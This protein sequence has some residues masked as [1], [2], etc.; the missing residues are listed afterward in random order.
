MDWNTILWYSLCELLLGKLQQK[1]SGFSLLSIVLFRCQF[2]KKEA[3][4]YRDRDLPS[5]G[6][7]DNNIMSNSIES[8]DERRTGQRSEYIPGTPQCFHLLRLC[9]T[10]QREDG[11]VKRRLVNRSHYKKNLFIEGEKIWKKCLNFSF[12][13][14]QPPPSGQLRVFLP[15]TS[16]F[17][18]R[19]K[20]IPHRD[21]VPDTLS[22]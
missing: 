6:L 11:L 9:I 7:G 19:L 4:G 15:R 21:L 10:F 12:N 22:R 3:V 16:N 2:T 20:G 18:A 13:S 5:V 8:F 17:R 14:I 1:V